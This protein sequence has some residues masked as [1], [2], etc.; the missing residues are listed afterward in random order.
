[1]VYVK[2]KD[3]GIA[4][5]LSLE[6]ALTKSKNVEISKKIQESLWNKHV[7]VIDGV[8]YWISDTGNVREIPQISRRKN[9][10]KEIHESLNHRGIEYCYYELKKSIIGLELRKQ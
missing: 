6:Q 3:M 5:D 9:L 1:M 8:E 10:V 4:V 7:K 2:G